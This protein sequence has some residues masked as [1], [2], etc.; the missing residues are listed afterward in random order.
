VK[1]GSGRWRQLFGGTRYTIM[2]LRR[3]SV[4]VDNEETDETVPDGNDPPA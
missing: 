2:S 3:I 4:D 1:C